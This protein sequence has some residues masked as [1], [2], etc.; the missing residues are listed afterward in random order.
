MIGIRVDGNEKIG[1]GASDALPFHC[2]RAQ[3]NWEIRRFFFTVDR[4]DILMRSGFECCYLE[5]VYDDLSGENLLPYLEKYGVNTLLVDTYFVDRAYFEKL[6]GKV[7]T[8][9]IFDFGDTGIPVDL[10]INYNFNYDSF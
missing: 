2:K 3:G 7:K 4:N 10:L 8:A 9:Y 6:E 1:D 5:G